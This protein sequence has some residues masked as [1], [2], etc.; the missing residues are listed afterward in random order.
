MSPTAPALT[1]AIRQLSLLPAE[2]QGELAALEAGF[3]DPV[4]LAAELQRRGWLTAYQSEQL[5][6]GDGHHLVLGSYVLLEKLG[7]GGMGAV[8]KARHRGLGRIV[9]LKL[10]RKD[11]LHPSSVQRFHR[12]VR[13]VAQLSHPN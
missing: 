1:H 10:L 5:L 12:E 7:E 9:A 8:F 2:Q 6:Q 4:E 13:A 11:R 3:P